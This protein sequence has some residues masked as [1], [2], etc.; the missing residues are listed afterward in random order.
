MLAGLN[1]YGNTTINEIQSRDHEN[2]I[3]VS[4]IIKITINQKKRLLYLV[5]KF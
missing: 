2:I 3:V 4:R 5:K 1:A